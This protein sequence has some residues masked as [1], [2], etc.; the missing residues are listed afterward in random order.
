M[1]EIK[2]ASY[3]YTEGVVMGIPAATWLAWYLPSTVI[4]YPID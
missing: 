4:L 3:T 1:V 2:A